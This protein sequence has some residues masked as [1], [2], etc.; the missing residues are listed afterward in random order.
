MEE[1]KLKCR[2]KAVRIHRDLSYPSHEPCARQEQLS[3]L[4]VG[5]KSVPQLRVQSTCC[6]NF[7]IALAFHVE[8]VLDA[9]VI[10]LIV[11]IFVFVF[12]FFGLGLGD[13]PNGRNLGLVLEGALYEQDQ[14]SGGHV[15]G[16][17]VVESETKTR[18]ALA[19]FGPLD[20]SRQH[21]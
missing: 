19:D 17:I 15:V 8:G 5:T 2:L 7:V 6:L 4:W 14:A 1:Q 9:S 12:V 10:G 13:G 16:M 20:E 18:Q 21:A 11:V 3:A